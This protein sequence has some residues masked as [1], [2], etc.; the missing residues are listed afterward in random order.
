MLAVIAGWVIFYHESLA[1]GLRQLGCMIGIN[2][3][4][5]SDT[6][7]AVCR[8]YF[9]WLLLAAVLCLPWKSWIKKIPALQ[10]NSAPLITA[11]FVFASLTMVLSIICLC[12]SSFNPFL[13]FRF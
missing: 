2:A 6:T 5:S 13:Y 9:L 11:K 7:L 1:D 10:K 8:T 3:A 12:G 4:A